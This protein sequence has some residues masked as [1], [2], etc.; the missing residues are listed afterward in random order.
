MFCFPRDRML[1]PGDLRMGM[2]PLVEQ[3]LARIGEG[4]AT[5]RPNPSQDCTDLGFKQTAQ[6]QSQCRAGGVPAEM[7]SQ[8]LMDI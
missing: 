7:S 4:K 8:A 5:G 2:K 6:R 1:D 3:L